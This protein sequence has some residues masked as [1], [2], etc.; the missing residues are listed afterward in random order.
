MATLQDIEKLAAEYAGAR[1]VLGTLVSALDRA[2]RAVKDDALPDIRDAI[3]VVNATREALTAAVE[4]SPQQFAERRTRTFHDIK[5]GFQKGKGKLAWD[6]DEKVIAKI[7]EL[8]I[9]EIGVL[10]RTTETPNK[11]ALAELP[12]ADLKKL[13][14]TITGTGDQVVVKPLD[15]Q[16]EQ[17]VGALVDV[18]EPRTRQKRRKAA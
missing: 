14:V 4:T 3:A 1:N 11:D 15:N 5:V 7:R 6:D 10:I 8:Y 12:A 18:E 2:I 9:D 17:L 16:V 13:G